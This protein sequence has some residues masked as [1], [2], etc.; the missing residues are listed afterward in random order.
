[1]EEQDIVRWVIKRLKGGLSD[2]LK[3]LNENGG[4]KTLKYAKELLD[5]WSE[6]ARKALEQSKEKS[7]DKDKSH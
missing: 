4:E 2:E 6:E 3:G 5:E 1:M 7:N